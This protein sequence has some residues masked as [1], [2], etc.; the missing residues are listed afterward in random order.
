[1]VEGPRPQSRLVVHLMG[2]LG[3]QLFQYAFGRRLALLNGADLWL[4]ARGYGEPNSVGQYAELRTYE[5]G[6]YNIQ[7]KVLHRGDIELTGL[8]GRRALKLMRLR[9]RWVERRRPYYDRHEIEEPLENAFRF[10]P[11]VANR[12]F[13]GTLF[14]R[15]FWQSERYFQD[16]EDILRRDLT[17]R[18][19]L[20]G[21]PRDLQRQLASKSSVA[22]HVRHGDNASTSTALGVLPHSYYEMAMEAISRELP[23]PRFFVFS[24]DIAWAQDFLGTSSK[25]TYVSSTGR[26]PSST[27]LCLMAC[28]RHHITANSTFSWWGAWLGKKEGQIVYAPRRYYQNIDRPNPDFYPPGWRLLQP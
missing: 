5:I 21:V 4:D 8:I 2:G 18:I 1:M 25:L 22:V 7:A 9:T 6:D 26:K 24:D 10:D 3:N 27:D 12:R 23:A 20:P 19:E 16:I 28:C 14:V 11:A 13:R 15:G 17:P